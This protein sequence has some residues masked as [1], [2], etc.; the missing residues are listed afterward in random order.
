M[1]V[2]I[3]SG[4]YRTA[5]ACSFASAATTLLLIFMPEFYAPV[6]DDI[7]GRMQRVA[8]PAYQVRAW[9]YQVHPFLVFTAA[10]GVAAAHRRTSPALAL[11][12]LLGFALWAITEAAQ[13]SLT[14]F[15]F[16]DW[17]RAWLA[18]DTVVRATIEVRTAVYDGLWEAAYSLLLIGFILGNAFFAAFLLQDEQAFSRVVGCFFVAAA[19]LS[20]SNLSAE[21]GGP[22]LP[23][24]VSYWA[25]PLIQ[26]IGRA[27][28]GLWLLQRGSSQTRKMPPASEPSAHLIRP[29]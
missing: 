2:E 6:P 5:A 20:L 23:S 24:E 8:D 16:D 14:L 26:P 11:G 28:I 13:Q 7:A 19:V 27:L 3:G 12:G 1:A 18:G 17:R 4:L 22:T 29:R 9:V 10:L 21:V 25:Y 15:A